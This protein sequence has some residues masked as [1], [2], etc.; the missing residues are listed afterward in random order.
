[1]GQNA[2]KCTLE[3][4]NV[5]R[6]RFCSE[7]KLSEIIFHL[8]AV[9]ESNSFIV[10]WLVPSALDDVVTSAR[11][12]DQSF[13]QEYKITS[14]TLDGRCLYLMDQQS[15]FQR[16]VSINKSMAFLNSNLPVSL[17]DFR[18]L[19]IV[20]VIELFGTVQCS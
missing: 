7:V 20:T 13:Y 10:R 12:V 15:T 14:L 8:V 6:K 2:S 5:I 17:M 18:V 3:E 4:L 9:V 16:D 19:T 11:N 1:V